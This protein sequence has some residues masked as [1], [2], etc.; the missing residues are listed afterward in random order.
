M[1]NQTEALDGVFC[2][3]GYLIM[4]WSTST[5]SG[6]HASINVWSD[7]ESLLDNI[8]PPNL[9]Q[10][11]Q[12]QF[13]NTKSG[14]EQV[15]EEI[16]RGQRKRIAN[17]NQKR[18]THIYVVKPDT[19]SFLDIFCFN[20]AIFPQQLLCAMPQENIDIVKPHRGSLQFWGHG[21]CQKFL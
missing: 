1:Q 21:N 16:A 7:L 13:T 20:F 4:Q 17:F 19:F 6:C 9:R 5:F 14:K 18:M 10:L 12:W 15:K 3:K 8:A 2:S 11:V